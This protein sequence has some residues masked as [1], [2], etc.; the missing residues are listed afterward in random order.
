MEEIFVVITSIKWTNFGGNICGYHINEMDKLWMKCL[1]ISSMKWMNYG[2]NICGH[3]IITW[4]NS[5]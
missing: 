1:G 3:H 5:G 4:T 2:Q